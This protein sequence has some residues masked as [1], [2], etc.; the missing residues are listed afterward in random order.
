MQTRRIFVAALAVAALLAGCGGSGGSD[1]APLADA[2]AL[3]ATA[4][5]SAQ[6]FAGFI[7]RLAPS[8]DGEPIAL[9]QDMAPGDDSAEPGAL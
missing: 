9:G 6:A 5:A 1:P 4:L 2:S 8:E 7:A 3:P